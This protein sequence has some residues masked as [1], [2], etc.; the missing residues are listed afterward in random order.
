[1]ILSSKAKRLYGNEPDFDMLHSLEA[2]LVYEEHIRL[3]KLNKERI[4]SS[5]DWKRQDNMT[6]VQ[7]IDKAIQHWE[8]LEEMIHG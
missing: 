3:L 5:K 4:M 8:D 1:M 2:A 7:R 6:D